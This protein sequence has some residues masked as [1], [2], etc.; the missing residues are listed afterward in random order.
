MGYEVQPYRILRKEVPTLAYPTTSLYKEAI[1]KEA[2][3]TFI[4]G[5]LKT[6]R[7]TTIQLDNSVIDQG[8]F[9]ITNQCVNSD[10]FTYGSVF[11][12]EVGITLKTDIDR[13][14]LYDSEIKPYFNLLLSDGSYERIPLGKFYVNEPSR[15]GKSISIKAYDKMID[16]D[17]D[18][19]EDTTGTAYELLTYI[20]V[21]CNVILA[22]TEAEILELI[23]SE[24][25][26]SVISDRVGTYRDLLSYIAQTTCT[27]ALFDREG[28]LRLC[29]YGTE[30]VK[31]IDAKRRNSSKFSD[32]ETFYSGIKAELIEGSSYKKYA[33]AEAGTGLVYDAQEIPIVQGIDETNQAVIDKMFAKLSTVHYTPCEVSYKG[34]PSLDLGD[35]I[36]NIDRFGSRITSLITFY[37]WSYRGTHQIKS[38]GQN[39]K[40]AQI[41][42]RS[43]KEFANLQA[44]I[45]T[46]QVAVYTFTNASNLSIQGGDTSNLGSLQ[47][48]I[49][50]T[51]ATNSESTCLALTTIPFEMSYDG[52]VE[53][54]Q[55][56]D[57]QKLIDS[58][59]TQYC[60]RGKN[61]ITFSNYFNVKAGTVYR[62]T[63][64]A[65]TKYFESDIRLQQAK[66]DEL[67]SG[68]GEVSKVVPTAIISEFTLRSV[69]FGQGLVTTAPWDGLIT[70][71]DTIPTEFIITKLPETELVSII[72]DEG[73]A[74]CTTKSLNNN[75]FTDTIPGSV[76]V[77]P[78]VI[79]VVSGMSED[80]QFGEIIEE[81]QNE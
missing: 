7:G 77:M 41:K 40:L 31:E 42:D 22:Q 46:K 17:N 1:D 10:A 45:S 68:S 5:E 37:K 64:S 15:I 2:R 9:Y 39:P 61:T 80:I 67:M 47:E 48:I 59:I 32:F 16:L 71:S 51:F 13:Y 60:H 29:E 57:G 43:N 54:I 65:L 78:I 52:E 55:F 81:E 63:V 30:V 75:G 19:D 62:Y 69:I 44:E 20:S 26:L 49:N 35:M 12:A 36:V 23:N 4:D 8:S 38:A 25:L 70:I 28:K 18:I 56:L 50:I 21:K 79:E 14:S 58:E 27:F 34:D 66:I 6:S 33:H 72:K 3:V 74:F 76:E 24:I 11:A 53:F 73:T